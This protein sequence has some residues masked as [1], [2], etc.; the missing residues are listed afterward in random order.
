MGRPQANINVEKLLEQMDIGI[1]QSEMDKS[2]GVSIPT[3]RNKI[4]LLRAEQGISLETKEVENLRVIRMKVQVMD[5]LET[6]LHTMESD[7]LLKALAT[8]N[9]MDKTDEGEKNV[10]G[11]LGILM[12]LDS[13]AERRADEKVEEKLME[14]KTIDVPSNKLPNL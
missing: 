7:D 5:R 9:K 11:L 10:K 1:P 4:D 13:E 3:L 6:Q 2:L 8:L 14:E 12:A